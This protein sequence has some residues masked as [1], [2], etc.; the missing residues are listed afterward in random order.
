MKWVTGVTGLAIVALLTACNGGSNVEPRSSALATPTGQSSN[1]RVE[2]EIPVMAYV[3]DDG[4]LWIRK[5]SGESRRIFHDQ[6]GYA[7]Y[8]EWSPDGIN[9]AFTFVLYRDQTPANEASLS[10]FYTTVVVDDVG[11]EIFRLNQALLPHWSPDGGSLS[12]LKEPRATAEF[13][14]SST[15]AIV[16]VADRSL[17]E[18]GPPIATHDAP[19]WSP[20]GASLAY[21]TPDGIYLVDATAGPPRQAVVGQAAQKRYLAPQWSDD[22]VIL[23]F[24]RDN[25]KSTIEESDSYVTIDPGEGVTSRVNDSN[26]EKCGRELGFRDLEPRWVGTTGS[27]AWGRECPGASTKPG[28]WIKDMAGAGGR[29]I[30]VTPVSES[31]ADLDVS[32][33]GRLVVFSDSGLPLGVRR[34]I[35]GRGQIHVVGVEGGEP[36]TIADGTYPTWRLTHLP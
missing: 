29:F 3:G 18:L 24:E 19:T 22:G 15:P 16:D 20:D 8:P 33:D 14:L 12:V 21:A 9:I 30:D 23:A 35:A 1:N 5:S 34:P 17:T 32:P 31:V 25:A 26:P 27:A 6:R 7:Y 2:L 10:A 28:I 36:T 4:G 13:E 11:K